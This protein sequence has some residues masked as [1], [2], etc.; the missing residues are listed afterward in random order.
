M[1]DRINVSV[2]ID[3]E[4]NKKIEKQ[5]SYSEYKTDWIREAIHDKLGESKAEA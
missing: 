1:G 4:T 2:P 3:E 5:L